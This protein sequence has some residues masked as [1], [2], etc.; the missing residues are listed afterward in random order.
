MLWINDEPPEEEWKN[1]W[2]SSWQ[3][4]VRGQKMRNAQ[5]KAPTAAGCAAS[6]TSEK[7]D[8]LRAPK[9]KKSHQ[10]DESR[11]SQN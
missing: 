7:Q 4:H 9:P 5:K 8:D 2:R 6:V 11:H 3:R 1:F 10:S